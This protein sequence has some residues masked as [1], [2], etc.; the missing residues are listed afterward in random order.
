MSRV[1]VINQVLGAK[2]TVILQWSKIS[3]EPLT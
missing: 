2:S 3:T 1:I